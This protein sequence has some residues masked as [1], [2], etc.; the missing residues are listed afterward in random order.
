MLQLFE[1]VDGSLEAPLKG[2]LGVPSAQHSSGQ[3]RVRLQH[4]HDTS[5]RVMVD[6]IVIVTACCN[7]VKVGQLVV[8]HLEVG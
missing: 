8:H 5:T 6:V 3:A 7:I 1:V 4:H 2:H